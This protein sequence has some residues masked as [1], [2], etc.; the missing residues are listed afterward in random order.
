MTHDKL[1]KKIWDVDGDSDA[2]LNSL[3]A[4][5][6]LHRPVDN[7]IELTYPDTYFNFDFCFSCRITPYPCPTIQAI[8]KELA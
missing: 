3:L 4:I 2:Y 5:V 1:I 6:Q 8:E 7:E